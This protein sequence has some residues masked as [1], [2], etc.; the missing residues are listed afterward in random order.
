MFQTALKARLPL[1]SATTDDLVNLDHVLLHWA[2]PRKVMPYPVPKLTVLRDDCLYWSSNPEHNSPEAYRRCLEAGSQ[3]LMVNIPEAPGPAVP[4]GVI[5]TPEKFIVEYLK[6]VVLPEN[7]GALTHT[8]KGCSLKSASEI[9]QLAAGMYGEITVKSV[10]AMRMRFSG[11]TPGLFPLSTDVGYW[12]PQTEVVDW[13]SLSKP[14]MGVGA[15]VSLQP[16]GLMLSGLPGT[17]KSMAAKVIANT[18]GVPA[19]RLDVATSLNRFIGESEGRMQ[20]NLD[21]IQQYSPCVVLLDEVEKVFVQ[22]ADEGTTQR[23]LS[24][25]LWFLQERKAPC[26]VIMTTNNL[27]AVPPELYR[28]GRLDE[29]ITLPPMSCDQARHLAVKVFSEVVG[30]P[31]PSQTHKLRQLF[32]DPKARYIPA[33]VN[34]RTIRMIKEQKWA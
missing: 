26:P 6:D 3:L 25:L 34:E 9:T 10:N 16:K 11:A 23:M 18:F 22:G 13:M 15:P 5:P 24:Q 12:E 29:V 31:T 20:R 14:Y 17:G 32:S 8:L 7:V 33:H 19:F 28:E 27:G 4:V 30:P 2:S 1:F 21:L